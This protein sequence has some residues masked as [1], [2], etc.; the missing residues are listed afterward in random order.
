[1]ATHRTKAKLGE[2]ALL[3]A[4]GIL[5][6][7]PTQCILQSDTQTHLVWLYSFVGPDLKK[8][9]MLAKKNGF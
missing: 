1:M 4:R 2:S 3:Q 7:D 8:S 6:Q 5:P 9:N